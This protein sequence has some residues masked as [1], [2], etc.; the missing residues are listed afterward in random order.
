MA[1]CPACGESLGGTETACPRCHLATEHFELFREAAG[2]GAADPKV[3][4]ALRELLDAAGV[5]SVEAA[6]GDDGADGSG[7][8]AVPPAPT[9]IRDRYRGPLV[10]PA[11]PPAGNAAALRKQV[12]E[13]LQF[14][15]RQGLDLA[16]LQERS[17]EA[18]V[19]EDRAALEGISRDLFVRLTASL[20][21]EIGRM[22]ARREDLAG[23]VE[24]PT[25][26]VELEG[27]RAALATGDL[28][29]TQ[30]R[31][32]HVEETIGRLEDEWATVQ[33]LTTEC[34]LI[35]GAIRELNGDPGPAVG[36]VEEG[37]RLARSG[38]RAE[39]EPILARAIQGLWAIATPL[40]IADMKRL[41]AGIARS[42]S[43]GE[44]KATLTGSLRTFAGALKRRNYGAAVV[45][46]QR[47]RDGAPG[48]APAAGA[49]AG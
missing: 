5:P 33:I 18:L 34:D 47:L 23:L 1:A 13:L 17:R 11:L 48:A 4:E 28:G 6:H 42:P 8:A 19:T 21:D 39:A 9:R 31:L 37:R 38:R 7:A 26:D 16:E 12:D 32:R 43:S 29:G 49:T 40:V 41:A 30:L 22:E 45:A 24:T 36:P 10:L 2:E 25:V 35:V 20:S 15:R 44:A 46:Y 14:G 3:G 27:S